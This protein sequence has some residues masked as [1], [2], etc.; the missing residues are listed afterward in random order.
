[1]L[2]DYGSVYYNRAAM[3]QGLSLRAE[4]L[5]I[6]SRLAQTHWAPPTH[7]RGLLQAFLLPSF[8][9][10]TS[11]QLFLP[12]SLLIGGGI[13]ILLHLEKAKIFFLQF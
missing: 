12:M 13:C 11:A 3:V 10:V 8:V 1:M 2:P 5:P 7:Q 4:L 6:V 9:D